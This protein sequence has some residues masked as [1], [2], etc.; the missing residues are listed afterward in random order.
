MNMLVRL[1]Q[2]ADPR[3]VEAALRGLG[4][5]TRR[6]D[7]SKGSPPSLMI[8]QHSAAVRPA[9]IESLDGVAE[10]Q[11]PSS[12][13]PK[14]DAR[15]GKAVA[16]G[17]CRIGGD[18]QPVLM[19][20]PC[21]VESEEQIEQAAA[22]AAA[23]GARLLRGGAFKPR[24]SP[25]SFNGH[26]K[27]ALGWL[28]KAAD[29]HGL[30]VVTEVMSEFEVETVAGVADLVQIGSRNM[31]NYALLSRVGTC[32]RPVLLKR[33]MAATVQE[34]LL[35]GEHLLA[36][37]CPGIVFCERGI[38]SFDPSTRNLLD[39]GAV[40]VLRHAHGLPVVVDPSHAAGRRDLVVAL[41]KAAI[42]CG[43]HGLIVESHPN[44]ARALSD[45]P[46][47][48]LPEQLAELGFSKQGEQL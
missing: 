8:E 32:Q 28:R 43:A 29:R 25:Y 12:P 26:G 39:L 44:P 37:G 24:S 1:K 35:A 5:W 19:T 3:H 4:L 36:A 34:W 27:R 22:S 21:S 18:A 10:V 30:G 46:Q 6:L 2:N 15:V 41:G 38:H 14:L 7:G 11:M 47:A 45:G 31:Q 40:A 20:G 13:H 33:G 48:L 9:N 16:V 23:A 42:A 17:D